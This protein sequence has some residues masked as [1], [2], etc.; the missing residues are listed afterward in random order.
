MEL[1]RVTADNLAQEHICCAIAAGRDVSVQSKKEWLRRMFAQGLVFLKGNVRGKCF[2]EYLPAE[3]AWAPVHAPNYMFIDCLWVSGQYKGQG[4]SRLLLEECI[5]DSKAKGKSGLCMVAASPK[6]PFLS[7]PRYLAH[8]GFRLADT[9]EPYFE[10]WYLPF[11]S[12][13]PAPQFSSQAKHPAAGEKG[14]VLYYTHQCPFT[15]KYVP[16]LVQ[17][18]EELDIPFQAVLLDSREK[19]QSAPSAVTSFALFYDGRFVTHEI[20]SVKKF[21][22]LAVAMAGERP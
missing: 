12:D 14:F 4:N 10:L 6:K 15:A 16:L 8:F 22:A 17:K 3:A 11:S 9:A 18:A 21:E 20:L 7:D 13:I 5:L 2:I 1:I 19:A